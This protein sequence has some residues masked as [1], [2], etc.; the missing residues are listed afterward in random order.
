[1]CNCI[2]FQIIEFATVA[3]FLVPVNAQKNTAMEYSWHKNHTGI[4]HTQSLSHSYF[5][6]LPFLFLQQ[7]HPAAPLH[8]GSDSISVGPL[9]PP[10]V[11]VWYTCWCRGS[12]KFPFYII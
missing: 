9:A 4:Y 10:A 6:S 11:G 2:V 12:Y 3:K 7:K 5:V 1:M 8:I